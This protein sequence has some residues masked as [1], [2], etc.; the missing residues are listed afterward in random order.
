[1]VLWDGGLGAWGWGFRLSPRRAGAGGDGTKS[2]GPVTLRSGTG[3]DYEVRLTDSS[4]VPT[5]VSFFLTSALK[6]CNEITVRAYQL[7]KASGSSPGSR[8]TRRS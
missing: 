4:E 3:S 6:S 7:G 1:M 2:Q 8:T 5:Y